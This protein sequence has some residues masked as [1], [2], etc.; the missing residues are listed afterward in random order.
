[1][2]PR[3]LE[4]Y[5]R[6]LAYL[7]E[8]GG[9][10]AREY[11]KVAGRLGMQ[12]MDIA[13]PYVER[14][15]E[16]FSF[17]S[18]RIQIKLDAE[19]PRFSQRLLETVYP[20][21]LAPV[22]SICVVQVGSLGQQGNP[23]EAFHLPRGSRL[24][25]RL[26]P[27]E[28]TPCEFRT[29]HDVALWP[30]EISEA[31][32]TGI[33]ADLPLAQMPLAKQPK[34]ALRLRLRFT[35]AVPPEGLALDHLPLF[36]SGND[37][38]ATR[39]MELIH[40]HSIAVVQC[41]LTRPLKQWRLLPASSIQPEGFDE[42][43]SLLPYEAKAFQG[44]RLLHEYFAFPPRYYF[45]SFNG[46]RPSMARLA[47]EGGFELVVLLDKT[48]VELEPVVDAAQFALHCTP[49]INLI[50]RRADRV[51]ISPDRYE[52]HLV[53]DRA[54][55]LDY[56]V[57]SV[58]C[59]EG[60]GP[61]NVVAT[62][63]RPFYTTAAG[64]CGRHGAYYSVRR[65]PR[66]LSDLASRRGTR[67][68]YIGS[69]VFLSLVDQSEAPFRSDLRQLGVE[70]LVTNRDLPLLMPLGGESD[71][72]LLDSAPVSSIKVLRGPSRPSPAIAEAEITWR[73]ISHLGLNYVTLTDQD[74]V[75]G[76]AALRELFS[77]YASV[78]DPAIGNH[79]GAIQSAQLTPVTRRLPGKG[80]L[81]FGRGIGLDLT[82]DELRFAGLS[83]FLFGSV[84][85]Q[86]LARHVSINVFTEMTL[87]SAQRGKLAA[88]PPR[89]G[90]RPVV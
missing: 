18:A 36:L 66:V 68:S 49:A 29:A 87:S 51:S 25:A 30:L 61:D 71:F 10:F 8:L 76:A 31:S 72:I 69:E 11:P 21:F 45:L 64:D 15:L 42:S 78:A 43:Q 41:G 52:Y 79:A 16:G 27:G 56:E 53:V 14:L 24:R 90:A 59:V 39:L 38:Q 77:L 54:C 46:L 70:V 5:N 26:A 89:F 86:F 48:A 35:G 33:P 55:P 28:R 63:F 73:L 12:G 40:G 57:Y 37:E 2:D 47:E 74:E 4:Y 19:F 85:E 13:D 9:E 3:L 1:M 65:E 6:E 20:N 80:P 75:K 23:G 67:T 22:P 82:V 84:L 7:K 58:G 44:Y 60:F 17:L 83:P 62:H 88:W 81:V 50:S 34:A 32:I